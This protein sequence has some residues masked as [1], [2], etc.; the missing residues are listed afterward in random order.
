MSKNNTEKIILFDSDE[1]AEY[2]TNISGWVSR[3]GRFC[4]ENEDMARYDGCTHQT[5]SS[6]DETIEKVG[7]TI[8]NECRKKK[9]IAQYNSKHFMEWDGETPLYSEFFDEYIFED[10]QEYLDEQIANGGIDEG[11]SCDSLMLVICEPQTLG[12]LD[13]EHWAEELPEDGELPHEVA[14][15][16]KVFNEALMDAGTVSWLPGKFRTG[17]GKDQ[18]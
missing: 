10:P 7:Y 12:M 9:K 16:L 6:C 1:A 14:D 5:C 4:G 15:A 17:L 8:C 18:S 13:D 3:H 11:L 2:R